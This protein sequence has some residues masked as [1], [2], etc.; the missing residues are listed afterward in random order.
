MSK[1]KPILD[2]KQ[3]LDKKI[4]QSNDKIDESLYSRQL[5]AIGRDAMCKMTT[6]SVLITAGENFSG[7][8]IELAKCI[9]LAGIKNVTL[10]ANIDILTYRDLASN[11]YASNDDIGKPFFNKVIT[12]LAAL[13]SN[14]NVSRVDYIDL[15]SL[16]KYDTVVFCDYSVYGLF[17]W[18]EYCRKNN[19]NFIMLQTHGLIFNLFCDFGDNFIVNDTDGEPA[20]TG[21]ILEISNNNFKTL[22]HHNTY[23]GNVVEIIGDVTGLI[24][25][26]N[27]SLRKFLVKET[28]GTSFELYEY[29]ERHTKMS[30]EQLQL[31]MYASSAK[32]IIVPNQVL[33]NVT[34]KHIKLPITLKFKSLSQAIND[35]SFVMFDTAVW[36]MPKILNHFMVAL[37]IWRLGTGYIIDK[38][39]YH[40]DVWQSYPINEDDYMSLKQLFLNEIRTS[41][42]SEKLV[43]TEEVD[44]IFNLLARTCAGRIC[45]VDAVAG[46][47]CAQEVIKAVAHK[48]TPTNQFIHFEALNILPDNY[49]YE[50]EKNKDD[51][52]PDDSRYDG[53]TWVFGKKFIDVLRDKKIFVVGAGAIGCEYI[54][55]FSAQ[56]IKNIKIADMDHIENSNLNR[57]F[58]F[59]RDSIGK[60]KALVLAQKA[61]ELNPD[62]NVTPYENKVGKETLHIYNS[63]FFKNTDIVA[64]A[65]DNVDGRLFM[66][67]QC[68]KHNLPMLESGTLGTKGNVQVVVPDLT[69]SYA[70]LQDPPE[71][72][73]AVCTIKLFPY[74]YEHIVQYARD[75]F[76]G[77]YTRIPSN[78]IKARDMPE[79]LSTMTPT[80]L[81]IIHEDIK[82]IT[83][84]CKNFKYCI[85]TAYK[86]WH[87]LFR[88]VISQ[89]IRKYPNDHKD[90]DGT[91][92]WS[93]NK[94]FPQSFEFNPQNKTDLDFIINFSH[95]W[96]DMLDIPANKRYGVNMKDKYVKFLTRLQPPAEVMCKDISNVQTEKQ[97]AK[98]GAKKI[99]KEQE[100][101]TENLIEDIQKM[102]NKKK[103]FLKK[104]KS[105][106]FEK[107]DD[108]NCHIEFITALSNKRAENYHIESKDRLTTKGIAGKIIP[109][110]AT[111]TSVVAGLI[112][113]EL[114][115]LVY[116]MID[117][118]Y[119]TLQRYR[120]G[121]FN[122]AVQMFGFSEPQPANVVNINNKNYTIW[123]K[124]VRSPDDTLDHL[125]DDWLSVLV[126]KKV[127][128]VERKSFMSLDFVVNNDGIIYSKLIDSIDNEMKSKK[129]NP[130]FKKLRDFIKNNEKG[131]H[132]FTISLKDVKDDDDDDVDDDVDDDLT[133]N[134]EEL[135]TM[136]NFVVSIP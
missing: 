22:E 93:G 80:E 43:M 56:G 50:R 96:A 28:S 39:T 68:V 38:N 117:K 104:V 27:G 125:I 95:I 98:G 36:D 120:Y 44:K 87:I 129:D 63:A 82:T 83:K 67:M 42:A 8:A 53:Q 134:K 2:D 111:T 69:E 107:D 94:T 102:I 59:N 132:H 124:D 103:D 58:L 49:I 115:K 14:V 23:A 11:Y 4:E 76:E 1:S 131:D 9:I 112:S 81:T 7:S 92:F 30:P 74:K 35:P 133:K 16:T 78:F 79:S 21:I 118:T 119:N 114:Y 77:F 41:K 20:R 86:Q 121:S 84:G 91:I 66:D 52:K 127:Q 5:Y 73:I 26:E 37:D 25:V 24:T 32:R 110:I 130:R 71:Q 29:T 136:V 85:N 3:D 61:K 31:D 106:S 62:V 15:S 126:K 6:S 47:L 122:L 55:N 99:L 113:L 100:L 51:Y 75:L 89:L 10:H 64:T 135:D 97:D 57:Q 18:N 45:G 109:A 116:G 123:T 128:G 70:A 88:D 108:T 13:N 54:K 90:D 34:F 60:S 12:S 40:S 19:V 72:S 105:I 17:G 48:F 65:L 101:T 33:Q 46:S